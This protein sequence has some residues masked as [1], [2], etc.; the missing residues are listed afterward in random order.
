LYIC[1]I[2]YAGSEDLVSAALLSYPPMSLTFVPPDGSSR[3]REVLLDDRPP[4]YIE[5]PWEAAHC[6]KYYFVGGYHPEGHSEDPESSN[7][8]NNDS[9]LRSLSPLQLPL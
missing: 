6:E 8:C 2:K 3:S 4:L 7:K 9:S 1:K 5:P